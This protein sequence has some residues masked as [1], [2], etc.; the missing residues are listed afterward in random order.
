MM[1]S[2][3]PALGCIERPCLKNKQARHW[4]LTRAKQTGGVPA[5]QGQSP[6]FKPPSH[7]KKNKQTKNFKGIDKIY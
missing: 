4:W 2:A 1:A 5:L 3:S 7:Q 6:K